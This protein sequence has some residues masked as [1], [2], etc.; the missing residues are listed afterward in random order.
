MQ[1][2]QLSYLPF[3]V[4]L[5]GTVIAWKKIQHQY[6][7]FFVAILSA[8]GISHFSVFI[9]GIIDGLIWS[10]KNAYTFEDSI[11][12]LNIKVGVYI[13]AELLVIPFILWKL[14]HVFRKK[15]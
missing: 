13:A 8:F 9:A 14:I 2:S 10:F 7:F 1:L 12:S 15:P 4:S 3:T 11:Q 5:I 6:L